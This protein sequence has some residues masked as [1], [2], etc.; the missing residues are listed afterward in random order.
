LKERIPFFAFVKQHRQGS[1][2]LGSGILSNVEKLD[3]KSELLGPDVMLAWLMELDMSQ[4]VGCSFP[5]EGSTS[6]NWEDNVI[7]CVEKD[8]WG[9]VV[10]DVRIMVQLER[11]V[12]WTISRKADW[13]LKGTRACVVAGWPE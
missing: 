7:P 8:D 3:L 10:L 6:C 12:Q 1:Q 4:N 11:T 13:R 2:L 5:A 9:R